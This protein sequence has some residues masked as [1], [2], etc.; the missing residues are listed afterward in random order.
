MPTQATIPSKTLHHNRQINKI[1]HE[2]TKFTQYLSINPALQSIIDGNTNT[3]SKKLIFKQNHTNIIPPQQE[4]QQEAQVTSGP[5]QHWGSLPSESLNTRKDP[6][7]I[8]H[9]IL[10]SLVSGTQCLFQ[11]NHTE[12]ETALNREIVTQPDQGHKSH[13]VHSSTSVPCA[14]SFWTPPRSSQ[15]P[16]WDLKTFGEWNTTSARRQ[17]RRPDIWAPSLQEESLAAESTQTTET[18]ERASL[19]GLLIEAN[20][21]T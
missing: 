4:N 1:F 10:R 8:Q 19:P 17:V 7:R 12:P 2:K 21:I 16:P 13:P 20:I 9:G 6:H 15:D 11:S 14:Q 3:R 18:K 5:L